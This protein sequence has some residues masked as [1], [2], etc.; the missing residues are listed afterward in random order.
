MLRLLIKDEYSFYGLWGYD[1]ERSTSGHQCV[2][3][4]YC[5]HLR[6]K[7]WSASLHIV[8]IQVYL[9]AQRHN[10]EDYTI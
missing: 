2:K 9:T 4:L 5:L 7:L 8:A 10:P 1:D 3:G 6:S